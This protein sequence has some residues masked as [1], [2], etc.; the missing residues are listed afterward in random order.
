[1]KRT[2]ASPFVSEDATTEGGVLGPPPL[3]EGTVVEMGKTFDAIRNK[4]GRTNHEDTDTAPTWQKRF[5]L[6]AITILLNSC[7]KDA[8]SSTTSSYT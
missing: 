5:V 8:H 7:K 2:I 4:K 6:V 1:M 3:Q